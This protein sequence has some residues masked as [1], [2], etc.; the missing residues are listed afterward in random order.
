MVKQEGGAAVKGARKTGTPGAMKTRVEK[1]PMPRTSRSTIR[2]ATSQTLPPTTGTYAR[3]HGTRLGKSQSHSQLTREELQPTP[4]PYD[5]FEL[6]PL[7]PEQE[8]NDRRAQLFDVIRLMEDEGLATQRGQMRAILLG[9]F[10]LA[11]LEGRTPLST[12]DRSLA[13]HF[14]L[15]MVEVVGA[16]PGYEK[17]NRHLLTDRET[18][19]DCGIMGHP[20]G[21]DPDDRSG[22]RKDDRMSA[23]SCRRGTTLPRRSRL[24]ARTLAD[25]N[26]VCDLLEDLKTCG[27]GGTVTLINETLAEHAERKTNAQRIIA[28]PVDGPPPPGIVYLT[29]QAGN[30][31]GYTDLDPIAQSLFEKPGGE[32]PLYREGAAGRTELQQQAASDQKHPHMLRLGIPVICGTQDRYLTS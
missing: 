6:E 26:A 7:D 25:W 21:Q 15:R 28:A 1:T 23:S 2:S 31:D 10:L 29:R 3:R 27:K 12:V 20:D 17:E 4:E 11:Q 22:D 30:L 32:S 13:P 18:D 19:P 24:S 5:E 9:E 8:L 14:L 16:S